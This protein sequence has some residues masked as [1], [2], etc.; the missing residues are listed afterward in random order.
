MYLTGN[1]EY[2]YGY[3]RQYKHTLV[4]NTT[5]H[6]GFTF[7]VAGEDKPTP[8][9]NHYR[10]KPPGFEDRSRPHLDGTFDV[11]RASPALS[12]SRIRPPTAPKQSVDDRSDHRQP[13]DQRGS[14][15]HPNTSITS[16]PQQPYARDGGNAGASTGGPR[17]WI[18]NHED[19]AVDT[20]P[21]EGNTHGSIDSAISTVEREPDPG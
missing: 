10:R 16:I 14:Q 15:N 19:D 11:E 4:E 8:P 20:P 7:T 12:W 18:P 21:T 17:T 3:I 2:R 6:G 1:T 9:S 13:A 5:Q